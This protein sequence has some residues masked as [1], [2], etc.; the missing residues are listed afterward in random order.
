MLLL[1]A[2]LPDLSTEVLLM[3]KAIRPQWSAAVWPAAKQLF[4]ILAG[5]DFAWAMAKLLMERHSLEEWVYGL[6]KQV[7]IICAF[8]ALLINGTD[9]MEVIIASFEELGIRGSGAGVV[10]SPGDIFFRGL[11]IGGSILD[12][13]S[14]WGHLTNPGAAAVAVLAAVLIV[15]SFTLITTSYM[16]ALIESFIV[17]SAGM[18]LLGFGG[19][20]FTQ[21]YVER[22][23]A[24][25]VATGLKIMLLYFLIGTGM[26]VSNQWLTAAKGLNGSP[27]PGDSAM[28]IMG[29][30]L[31]FLLLVWQ[32]PKMFSSMLSGA[33]SLTGGDAAGGV[34]AVAGATYMAA[35][36][37]LRA[38]EKSGTTIAAGASGAGSNGAGSASGLPARSTPLGSNMPG[39]VPVPP[40]SNGGGSGGSGGGSG[41]SN[42]ARYA[43]G[44]YLPHEG[45]APPPPPKMPIE[46]KD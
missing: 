30:S 33:P 44:R 26:V 35:T 32:I 13:G 15:I 8:Y 10:L 12:S 7:M 42:N 19:S 38:V 29:A 24:F 37:L 27:I 34:M 14:T 1:Q 6:L 21:S 46:D 20:R 36:S 16:M 23:I 45:G 25:G 40:R 5:I 41:L 39:S 28:A 2:Q 17:I 18:I 43:A 11:N 31:M 9:W 3:Y 22:F 4:F